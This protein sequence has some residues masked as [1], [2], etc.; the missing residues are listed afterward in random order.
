[1]TLFHRSMILSVSA[2]IQLA[3]LGAVT[4]GSGVPS[5][6]EIMQREK[7]LIE[8][9]K[10]IRSG[11]V[12]VSTCLTKFVTNPSQENVKT[13]YVT[14]FQGDNIR[15]DHEVGKSRS[16]V[17]FT[18]DTHIRVL[19]NARMVQFFGSKTRPK[20]SRTV[21]DPRRLG[22][23]VW[24]YD[25]ISG[26]DYDQVFLNPN[27]DQFKIE[28]GA[29]AG[30]PVWKVSFRLSAKGL[31]PKFAFVE[32]HFSESKG[33]LPVYVGIRAGEGE[34][35]SL[36]SITVKLKQYGPGRVWFP[37]EVA[38]RRVRTGNQVTEE[39]IVTVEEAAFEEVPEKTFTLA[40]LGLP[41]GQL[42]DMD[43]MLLKWNGEGLVRAYANE[44]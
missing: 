1:M 44:L 33:G 31:P 28:A 2:L 38:F 19:S 15:S 16:Q 40:G 39:Q 35:Q 29:D 17:V 18:P 25:T 6:D 43:G 11:R 21:P 34:K 42:V 10:G 37:S 22:I 14:Y 3:G 20:D 5:L 41:K 9:R 12:T 36:A 26:H 27:R 32:Y 24:V 8:S 30:E 13:R 7:H 23:V 4:H